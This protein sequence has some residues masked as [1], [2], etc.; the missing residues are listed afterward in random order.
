[1]TLLRPLLVSLGLC[2]LGACSSNPSAPG[3]LPGKALTLESTVGRGER[4]NF[5]GDLESWRWAPDGTHLIQGRGDKAQW[6]HPESFEPLSAAEVL[7]M[8][9][10]KGDYPKL[11]VQVPG[12]PSAP[13]TPDAS[14]AKA[15]VAPQAELFLISGPG[16]QNRKQLSF[17]S[18]QPVEL[19]ELSPDK[20]QAAY[21]QG[22]DLYVVQCASGVRRAITQDGS[23]NVFNGKLDWVYQEEIYGRGNFKA[24]WWSPDS[25]YVA[26]LRLDEA[27]VHPFTVVDHI[28]DGHFRV[29]PELTKYPKPGDPNPVVQLGIAEPRGL[30]E[31]RWVELE[32]YASDEPLV[33]RVLWHPERAQLIYMLQDRIQSWLELKLV[34]PASAVQATLLRETSTSWTNRT[35]APHW[36]PDG[37]F[38]WL[39]ERSGYRHIYHYRFD[40][41]LLQ[42][43]TDGPW[44]VDKIVHVTPAQ[45]IWFEGS[46]DGV[47][48]RNTYG[49]GLDGQNLRRMTQGAGSHRVSFNADHSLFL[50]HAS[51]LKRAPSVA[52]YGQDGS[53]KRQLASASIPDLETYATASWE[54]HEVKARDGFALDVALLKPV[55][56]DPARAY[57]V[58]LPTYSGPNAPSVYDRWNSSS[59]YQFLAQNGVIV[60]QVNV[61]SASGKGLVSTATCY[62]QLGIQELRDLEDA[63]DWLCAKPYADARRVG[64]TG[65]SYGGFM[66]A[67]ALTHGDRFALGIAASGVYDWGMYDTIY[68]ERYMSTP[69]LNPEG[70]AATSVIGAAKDL[71][72][73]LVLTHGIMDDNV[74]FQNFVQLVYALQKAGKSFEMMLYPQ[75]RHGIRDADQRWTARRLEWSA[76]Q[77]HLLQN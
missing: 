46:K 54:L 30:Q 17:G 27:E 55:G 62:K 68:T 26:F 1:M 40:G 11:V 37:S 28:E 75:A 20:S 65:G 59:W 35:P 48:G 22:N 64:I 49:V 2:T 52:L 31:V 76:I 69:A 25:K 61:R 23:P 63:V 16:E 21:V 42:Q 67:F 9:A 13:G 7:G 51:S 15:G 5:R 19:A 41:Y 33:V 60:M 38:L 58:W 45:E 4:V 10:E 72:G 56:F 53:L 44:A 32:A 29:K 24:F 12:S 73:H 3:P 39:S 70:Y 77:A 36:L 8:E 6:L 50:D 14:P 43:L 57:P 71:K 66:S 18:E 47:L 74:H 34:D